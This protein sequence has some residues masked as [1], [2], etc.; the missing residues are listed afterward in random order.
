MLCHLKL[1]VNIHLEN[2]SESQ[3]FELLKASLFF[4]L[5]ILTHTRTFTHT[6]VHLSSWIII[7][8]KHNCVIKLTLTSLLS[9]Q[10]Q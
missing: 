4:S 5:F 1:S 2:E 10:V 7:N 9:L 6:G 8:N 3:S